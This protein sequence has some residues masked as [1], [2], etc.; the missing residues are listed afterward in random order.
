MNILKTTAYDSI[1]KYLR[2]VM[3]Y[4]FNKFMNIDTTNNAFN[5]RMASYVS[6]SGKVDISKLEEFNSYLANIKD[7]HGLSS[8]EIDK[9]DKIIENIAIHYIEE[10]ALN[11]EYY[12]KRT[13]DVNKIG[14]ITYVEAPK[15]IKRRLMDIGFNKG[16]KI[17][18]ILNSSSMRA[19]NLKGSIIAVRKE[20]TSKIE[21]EL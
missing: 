21:V 6:D 10:K 3:G 20:D 11:L 16:T 5:E 8:K 17:K 15:E 18:P 1:I 7:A 14:K 9:F 4:S 19:Y 2:K 12:N 13:L